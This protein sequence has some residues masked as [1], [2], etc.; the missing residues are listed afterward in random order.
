[1]GGWVDARRDYVHVARTKAYSGT[2]LCVGLS[3]P[4][5][6]RQRVAGNT[7]TGT[8]AL[9]ALDAGCTHA[10]PRIHGGMTVATR[11]DRVSMD[12][13]GDVLL[14]DSRFGIRYLLLPCN[15]RL[16]GGWLRLLC[17]VLTL[18]LSLPLSFSLA[19]QRLRE[20]ARTADELLGNR[21]G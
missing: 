21:P 8:P 2:A 16:S 5:T 12:S 13:E 19:S 14:C 18:T 1:M 7:N 15:R 17:N 11:I 6:T 3:H 20:I 4:S 10:A 9:C